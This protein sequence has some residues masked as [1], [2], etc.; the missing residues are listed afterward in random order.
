MFDYENFSLN[1]DKGCPNFTNY[2]PH[3]NLNNILKQ[4]FLFSLPYRKRKKSS[5]IGL[6]TSNIH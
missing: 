4:M 6:M 3:N 5:L 2:F 1:F